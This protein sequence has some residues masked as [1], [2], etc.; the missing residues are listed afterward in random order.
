MYTVDQYVQYIITKYINSVF[1]IDRLQCGDLW[2]AR[3]VLLDARCANMCVD[4]IALGIDW[5]ISLYYMYH[6]HVQP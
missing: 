3:D 5:S 2:G 1:T 6:E 4:F